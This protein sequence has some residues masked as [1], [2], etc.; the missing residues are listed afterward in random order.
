MILEIDIE[1]VH[2]TISKCSS[3][4]FAYSLNKLR[5]DEELLAI[6]ISNS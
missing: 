3:C 2:A 4:E 6:A 5:N 1:I